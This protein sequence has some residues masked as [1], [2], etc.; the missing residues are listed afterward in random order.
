MARRSSRSPFLLLLLLAGCLQTHV[1][2]VPASNAHLF[3]EAP[4]AMDV[5]VDI[6]VAAE[7]KAEREAESGVFVA[8]RAE[9]DGEL[10]SLRAEADSL[11]AEAHGFLESAAA[12]TDAAFASL[13]GLLGADGGDSA[14]YGGGR[15]PSADTAVDGN[16]SVNVNVNVQASERAEASGRVGATTELADLAVA[17]EPERMSETGRG[18]RAAGRGRMTLGALATDGGL[19]VD[20]YRTRLADLGPLAETQEEADGATHLRVG[21]NVRV[22]SSFE[23]DPQAPDEGRVVVRMRGEE[24][25]EARARVR[26]HLVIDR[27]SSMQRTWGSV[28]AAARSLVGQLD[29]R[30][31]IHVVA[32]DAEAQVVH[33]LGRVGDGSAVLRALQ[34]ISVGG[35]TN[36]EAGLSAAYQTA[37]RARGELPSRVILLSDGVPNGGAFT[38]AELGPMAARASAS[39]TLTTTIGL[40]D[41]FDA[42]VL[43]AV[44]SAGSG[45]YHVALEPGSLGSSLEGEI[46]EARF[47]AAARARV[48]LN[49][50]DGLVLAAGEEAGALTP[51]VR[52]L[53]AGEERRFV[54]R[55]RVTSTEATP[56]VRVRVRVA[57]G[58]HERSA[59]GVVVARSGIAT[60]RVEA[61]AD[62]AASL[63]AAARHLNNGRSQQA[64]AA[65][66]AHADRFGSV[67]ADAQ[68]HVRV[69]SV[70]RVARGVGELTARA[71]H[72]ERRHFALAMGE[73]AARLGR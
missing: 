47:E 33:P 34:E 9:M 26:V 70:R 10:A 67:R 38:A 58:G 65:L 49:L 46:A 21:A 30:D 4:G 71:S 59:E 37:V 27:S 18:V 56:R 55:V 19:E 64:E 31:E 54:V 23:R 72:T 2:R 66:V 69:G 57:V 68:L 32:Y 60:A 11:T 29:P 12:A 28:L 16:V 13:D 53:A 15:A 6:D 62:L 36:I 51:E 41:S 63:D 14:S 25:A 48:Q 39:G 61:D 17:V 20:G 40:G 44:A 43:R 45:S 35:G 73:L 5:E 52:G 3:A 42:D 1:R 22:S 8:G 24:P 7:S 50:G